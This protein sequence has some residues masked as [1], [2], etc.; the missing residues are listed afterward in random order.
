MLGEPVADPARL[1]MCVQQRQPKVLLLD[2]ALLDRLGP[3][4]L[5]MI[6]PKVRKVRVLLLG[7]EVCPG[8]V[9]EILRNRFHGYLLTRCPSDTYVKAI[10]AVYRG[11][12]WLPRA[13]SPSA[14]SDL[15]E[16]PTP[17]D[18]KAESNRVCTARICSP[19][20]RSRSSGF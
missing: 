16:T 11:D 10:R 2:K 18:T 19:N 12:I 6:R 14:L 17:G 15:L 1:P 5:R 7:D 20:A 4:S 3:E 8:L 9:E 13:C